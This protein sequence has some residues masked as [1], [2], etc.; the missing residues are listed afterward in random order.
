MAVS[1][2]P[3]ALITLLNKTDAG[4]IPYAFMVPT[5]VIRVIATENFCTFRVEQL[6][7]HN[8]NNLDPKGTWSTLS[9][10]GSET[11][12]MMLNAAMKAGFEAQ[13][14]LRAKLQS[15]VKKKRGIL[16]P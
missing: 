10:H 11:P 4:Y 16:R 13:N 8:S 9:T 6:I 7:R 12:G 2:L 3:P 5:R 14:K 15:R 1:Q